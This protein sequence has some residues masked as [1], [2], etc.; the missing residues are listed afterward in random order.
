M[1]FGSVDSTSPKEYIFVV[2]FSTSMKNIMEER[3]EMRQNFAINEML[4]IYDNDVRDMDRVSVVKF[5]SSMEIVFNLTE[6]S[7]YNKILRQSIEELK[8]EVPDGRTALYSTLK[9]VLATIQN[10]KRPKILVV[11]VDGLDNCSKIRKS[12]I[13]VMIEQI[14]NLKVLILGIELDTNA[15]EE[16]HELLE[17]HSQGYVVDAA[18]T[19]YINRIIKAKNYSK[20]HIETFIC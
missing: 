5:S 19:D 1:Y 11:L 15:L 4:R 10:L 18:D 8:R 7:R 12:E 14:S 20:R 17:E 9:I 2:D 6:K 16:Y 3:D 13:Q